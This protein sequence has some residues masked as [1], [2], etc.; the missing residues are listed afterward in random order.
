[1]PV[2]HLKKIFAVTLCILAGC[3]RPAAPSGPTSMLVRLGDYEMFLDATLT[4]LREHDLQPR[5]VDRSRGVVRAGPS[6]SAQWFEFWRADARGG[7]QVLEASL[8]TMRRQVELRIEP[9]SDP[10][11]NR[12]RVVIEAIKERFNSP[13]RQVTTTSGALAIYSE[14]LPTEEGLRAAQLEGDQWV[15]LGRDGLLETY[16]LERLAMLPGVLEWQ[17]DPKVTAPPAGS[18]PSA[19]PEAPISPAGPDQ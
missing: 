16:L 10:S 15:P 1:M 11:E 4:M 13:S 6:T 19:E 9:V 3:Q 17:F 12:Y 8:H 2:R 7:Y 14:R 5:R 18:R